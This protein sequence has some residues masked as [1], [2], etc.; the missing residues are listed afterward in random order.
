L[1]KDFIEC[2][3]RFFSYS[4]NQQEYENILSLVKEYVKLH[5]H[6]Y[7]YSNLPFPF[8]EFNNDVV[9]EL[10]KLSY[11]DFSKASEFYSKI[12]SIIVK[13]G[14]GHFFFEPPCLSYFRVDLPFAFKP[15]ASESQSS[16][17]LKFY[18]V[19]S[20]LS[21]LTNTFLDHSCLILF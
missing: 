19:A 20:S 9:G 17:D 11:A 6:I 10:E 14:D 2:Y 15:V 1:I 21:G 3:D 16:F 8:D 18:G 12:I 5:T 7:S 13:C 4:E